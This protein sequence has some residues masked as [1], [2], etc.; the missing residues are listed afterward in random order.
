MLKLYYLSGSCA[1]VPHT[2]LYWANAEFKATAM[3]RD[4]IKSP[5]YLAINPNGNVP[6]L[7]DGDWSLS[8]NVAIVEYINALYPQAKIFGSGNAQSQA[9]ARQWLSF[10]NSDIHGKFSLVFGAARLLPNADETTQNTVK[11]AGIQAVLDLYVRADKTLSN[12]D[13]LTGNEITIADVYVYVTQRWA[14]GLDID[15]NHLPN[16]NAHFERV[17]QNNGVQAALKAQGVL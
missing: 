13:Y 11:Q 1:L 2:A 9:K 5:E 7:T 16:L 10:A 4:S 8:Q 15:L 12:Q 3:T 14:H 6:L 17:A